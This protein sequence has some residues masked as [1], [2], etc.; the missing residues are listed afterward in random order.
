[1]NTRKIYTFKD[2]SKTGTSSV[3]V[4]L[5]KIIHIIRFCKHCR[6]QNHEKMVIR[7]RNLPHKN[8]SLQLHFFHPSTRS[9]QFISYKLLL[10]ISQVKLAYCFPLLLTKCLISILKFYFKKKKRL[11][12]EYSQHVKNHDDIQLIKRSNEIDTFIQYKNNRITIK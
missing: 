5:N 8:T 10:I 6:K 3:L 4:H 12:F 7:C 9:M 1:M 2:F 11:H